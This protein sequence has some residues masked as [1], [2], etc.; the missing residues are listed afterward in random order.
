LTS[1][2]TPAPVRHGAGGFD[3]ARGAFDW[4]DWLDLV[5][6]ALSGLPVLQWAVAARQGAAAAAASAAAAVLHTGFHTMPTQHRPTRR[7]TSRRRR[8]RRHV[9][10]QHDGLQVGGP[11]ACRHRVQG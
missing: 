8:V 6:R 7:S 4:M 11:G 2:A 5:V 1:C 10:G 3:R 9:H